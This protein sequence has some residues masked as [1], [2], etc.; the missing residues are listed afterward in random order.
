MAQQVVNRAIKN[1][2]FIA[3]LHWSCSA[4]KNNTAVVS[5]TISCNCVY[6]YMWVQNDVHQLIDLYY[7]H[8]YRSLHTCT[9]CY[10]HAGVLRNHFQQYGPVARAEIIFVREILQ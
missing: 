9:M 7:E 10:M 4:G 1:K 5:I 6:V 8:N 3:K 2:L